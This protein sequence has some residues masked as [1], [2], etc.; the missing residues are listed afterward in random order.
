MVEDVRANMV[1][2]LDVFPADIFCGAKLPPHHFFAWDHCTENS[3]YDLAMISLPPSGDY[4]P[5]ITTPMVG[6]PLTIPYKTQPHYSVFDL[7]CMHSVYVDPCKTSIYAHPHF[8]M[9][10]NKAT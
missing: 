7:D 3:C 2:A 6:V 4:D 1:S 9:H 5:M 10:Y 8:Y